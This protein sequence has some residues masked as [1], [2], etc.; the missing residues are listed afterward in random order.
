MSRLGN[1]DMSGLRCLACDPVV[2]ATTYGDESDPFVRVVDSMNADGTISRVIFARGY[3][4]TID[5]A[6]G[7]K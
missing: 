3:A 6:V 2:S 4:S 5:V 1:T 7:V